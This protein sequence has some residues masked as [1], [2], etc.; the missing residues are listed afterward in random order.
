MEYFVLLDDKLDSQWSAKEDLI[1]YIEDL[2]NEGD[3]N[4]KSLFIIQGEEIWFDFKIK[5]IRMIEGK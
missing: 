4:F 2:V 3:V 1:Q 5:D